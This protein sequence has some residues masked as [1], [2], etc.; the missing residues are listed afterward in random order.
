MPLS[1]FYEENAILTTLILPS[2]HEL[3]Q[4]KSKKGHWLDVHI[5]LIALFYTHSMDI[6]DI[7]RHDS[8]HLSRIRSA[9]AI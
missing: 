3:Q 8:R 1:L 6:S 5:E 4:E 7:K 2:T 9:V